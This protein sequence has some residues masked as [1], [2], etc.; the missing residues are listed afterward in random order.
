MKT[1]PTKV[2]YIYNPDSQSPDELIA[3][4]VIRIKEFQT[5]FR[6]IKSSP[7]ENP[8]QH[9]IIQGPRGSGKTTLLLRVYYEIRNDP[10]LSQWLVPIMFSEE[11]YH[12]RSLSRLWESAA[13]LLDEYDEFK[14]IYDIFEDA[15]DGADYEDICFGLLSRALKEQGKKLVLFIDNIGDMLDRLSETEHHRLREILLT[16]PDIRM[17][18]ASSVTLESTYDYSKPF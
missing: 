9:H 17:V 5:V 10:Q 7:M 14:G 15:R 2:A 11:Q 1:L 12:I 18:G 13:E 6:D 3:N 8:E 4:F 16:S